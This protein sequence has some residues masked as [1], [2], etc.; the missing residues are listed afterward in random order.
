MMMMM[1][2]T[3]SADHERDA[4]CGV[5]AKR[6]DQVRCWRR[7][8]DRKYQVRPDVTRKLRIRRFVEY[9]TVHGRGFPAG[10]SRVMTSAVI[11]AMTYWC[12]PSG[13]IV[14]PIYTT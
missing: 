12:P 5:E 8:S 9:G 11:S 14:A 7:E 3:Q 1:I 10:V 6:R 2:S 4:E 13:A